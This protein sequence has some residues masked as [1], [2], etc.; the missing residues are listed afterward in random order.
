MCELA[1]CGNWKPKYGVGPYCANCGFHEEEHRD[2]YP[3][4][5]THPQAQQISSLYLRTERAG[6]DAVEL[7][8]LRNY[9]KDAEGCAVQHAK[10]V[11]RLRALL[12]R[13]MDEMCHVP[14]PRQSFTAT[15]D[16]IDEALRGG[17]ETEKHDG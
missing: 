16:E 4:T 8:R 6:K 13:A 3:Y 2:T 14:A 12:R 15:V 17:V 11:M 1:G 9:A 5:R 10:T 7:E